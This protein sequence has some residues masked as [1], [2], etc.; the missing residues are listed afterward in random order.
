MVRRRIDYTR[1][2]FC[3]RGSARDCPVAAITFPCL[4]GGLRFRS[5][6]SLGARG[7]W[8]PWLQPLGLLHELELASRWCDVREGH[9]IQVFT[10][11]ALGFRKNPF[12]FAKT[13]DGTRIVGADASQ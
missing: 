3:R 5:V 10:L 12:E 8:H 7:G 9:A 11:D 2:W 13:M 6:S 4:R 1:F